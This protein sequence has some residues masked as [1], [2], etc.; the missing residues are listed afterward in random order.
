MQRITIIVHGQVQGV[1]YRYTTHLEAAKLGLT[2][3]V[4]NCPDG[5]VEIVAEGET[6]T[7]QTLLDWAKIGPAAAQ[8]TRRR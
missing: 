2:G 5:T 7:L 4:H 8:V 1:G 3:Y 6:A